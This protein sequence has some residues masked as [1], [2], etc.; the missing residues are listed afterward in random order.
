MSLYREIVP[1]L[2]KMLANLAGWLDAAT[3][4]ANARG[5]DPETFVR[6]RL[7]PDQF[8]LRRQVQATCDQAKFAAARVSGKEPPK[9]P[10]TEQ[11]MDELRARIRTVR[12]YLATFSEQ[13]F[14]G[15]EARVVPLFFLPGKGMLAGDWLRELGLPNFY[16][17]ATTAYA[18][19]RSDGV[20]L[21]KTAFIGS[22]SLRDL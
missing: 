10:D 22:L 12:E 11:T 9:H 15:A 1:P 2:D 7:A 3:A 18:I 17:H 8:D 16:F 4:H 20:P 5:F 6:S 14:E 13:D 21:G 19:L